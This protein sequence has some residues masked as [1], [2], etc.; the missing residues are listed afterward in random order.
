MT[1]VIDIKRLGRLF[2]MLLAALFILSACTDNN[3]AKKNGPFNTGEQ[4]EV[5]G[6]KAVKAS[7]ADSV[8]DNCWQGKVLQKIYNVAGTVIIA[9]YENLTKGSLALMSISF[10]VWVAL[11][12]LKFVSSVTEASP[13]EI[14]NEIIRKAFICMFCGYLASSSVITLAF[15]NTFI[16]PIYTAFL[17]FAGRILAITQKSVS[18]VTV[19]GEEVQFV[20]SNITCQLPPGTKVSISHNFPPE[21]Q[22]TMSCMVCAVV[23][24]LRLGRTLAFK[25]MSMNGILPWLIGALVWAIFYV[26]GFAF[27]FYLVDSVFRFGM[28]MVLLPLFIMSYA[29]GP[30]KKWAGLGFVNIMYSAAYMMAFS[31]IVATAI[32]AII[33]FIQNNPDIFNP[34]DSEREFSQIGTSSITIL[35]MGF[36]ILGSLGVA[37]SLTKTIIGGGIENKFQ[38][39]LK[40]VAQTIKNIITGGISK[41]L[42]KGGFYDTKVGQAFKAPAALKSKLD[43]LAGRS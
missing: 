43:N 28:M 17:E 5:A 6:D 7:K 24:K 29:F 42:N 41:A 18:S 36:L 34:Q 14:W 26:V 40:A 33:E 3:D 4:G 39:N 31:I 19:F 25:A 10:A 20:M 12:L 13:A 2:V 16:I 38:Q 32:L 37:Q 1:K 9:Q 22:E 15:V 11:R 23:D 30:T 27:V 8:T 35:L 21:F